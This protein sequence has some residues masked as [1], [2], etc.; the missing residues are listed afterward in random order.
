MFGLVEGFLSLTFP[1]DCLA[2]GELSGAEAFCE[3][4]ARLVAPRAGQRCARCD[5]GVAG[6]HPVCGRCLVEP[7]PFERG[8][9]VFDYV[10]PVGDA[11]RAAK[12][13]AR[14]EALPA[15]ATLLRAHLPTELRRDPPGAVLGVPLHPKRLKRRGVDAPAMLARTVARGLGVPCLTGVLVRLRDT[16]PQAGLSAR[17]R[18]VNVTGAFAPGRRPMPRD[19]LVV[20]DITT[21]GAT[22]RAV[23]AAAREAGAVRVRV[24]TAA[25]ADRADGP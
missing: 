13:D 17:E 5:T 16:R 3:T 8:Y 1:V 7:P 23:A 2:C 15:V 24:L 20:D 9:G 4:C 22:L 10:G 11:I 12:Y 14:P 21:T 25:V 6:V 19:V 18:A